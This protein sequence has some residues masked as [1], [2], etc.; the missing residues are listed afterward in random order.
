MKSSGRI[1]VIIFSFG[2]KEDF[3]AYTKQ[4]Y[5]PISFYNQPVLYS[6]KKKRQENS[7]CGLSNLD[8]GKY[9]CTEINV[10]RTINQCVLINKRKIYA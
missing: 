10:I 5:S 2:V 6:D 8:K 1:R 4:N 9:L 3:T 7:A